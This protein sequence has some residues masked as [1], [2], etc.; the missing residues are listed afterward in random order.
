MIALRWSD[1]ERVD[2]DNVEI[3]NYED[4]PEIVAKIPKLAKAFKKEWDRIQRKR[5]VKSK[6][7]RK[8]GNKD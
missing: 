7:G 1:N 2:V 6:R 4:D 8:P 5:A 3:K